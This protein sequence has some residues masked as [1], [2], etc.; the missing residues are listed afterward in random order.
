[1]SED[2]TPKPRPQNLEV[3]AESIDPMCVCVCVKQKDIFVVAKKNFLVIQG[4]L[5]DPSKKG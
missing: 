3:L 4:W 1:M 2:E 5:S